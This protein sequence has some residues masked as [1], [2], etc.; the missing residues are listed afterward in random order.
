MLFSRSALLPF[1]A[2]LMA[3]CIAVDVNAVGFD[4]HRFAINKEAT[5]YSGPKLQVRFDTAPSALHDYWGLMVLEAIVSRLEGSVI[6]FLPHDWVL[7]GRQPLAGCRPSN[8]TAPQYL[9]PKCERE[10]MN[11][12][13]YCLHQAF[14]PN[15]KNPDLDHVAGN[16]LV[17]ESARRACIYQ[18]LGPIA[19]FEYIDAMH[20]TSCDTLYTEW[21]IMESYQL[22]KE[23]LDLEKLHSCM[24]VLSPTLE[25]EN[26]IME[27]LDEPVYHERG[28]HSMIPT[29]RVN[30]ASMLLGAMK[31]SGKEIANALGLI[32]N[33]IPEGFEKPKICGFCNEFCPPRR[34]HNP[35]H[36][37]CLWE[38]TCNDPAK[39]SFTDY[40][41]HL[42]SEPDAD[43]DADQPDSPSQENLTTPPESQ[44]PEETTAPEEN[45]AAQSGSSSFNAPSSEQSQEEQS[46]EGVFVIA[47]FFITAIGFATASLVVVACLRQYRSK[48]IVDQYLKEQA[49]LRAT[50]TERGAHWDHALFPALPDAVDLDVEPALQYRDHV[51]A[52]QPPAKNSFLPKL[53]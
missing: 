15:F 13:R 33:S 26:P 1:A 39:T 9:T 35:N 17:E 10:C 4:R 23:K 27:Y 41:L 14:N 34:V 6:N 45:V 19:F 31:N 43:A 53:T 7:P 5:E 51:P 12:G 20:N 28:A 11:N 49:G 16:V 29:L 30:D 44:Q 3:C 52:Q 18:Q 24:G 37:L 38:L 48:A 36:L 46:Q 47:I 25:L 50:T 22:I 8:D 2:I 42:D 32:C 40:L 21:C